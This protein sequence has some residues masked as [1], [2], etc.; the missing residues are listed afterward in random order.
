MNDSVSPG[1]PRSPE[2]DRTV[3]RLL[4]GELLDLFGAA[5]V[6]VPFAILLRYL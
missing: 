1:A 6:I 3:N 4:E 5:V 2:Q